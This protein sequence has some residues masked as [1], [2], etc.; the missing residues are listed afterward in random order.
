MPQSLSPDFLVAPTRTGALGRLLAEVRRRLARADRGRPQAWRVE[1]VEVE[2][3]P[4]DPL[5]W[6]AAQ[7]HASR[8]YWHGRGDASTTAGAG[9]ANEV[10]GTLAQVGPELESR[11]RGLPNSQARYFGGLRFEPDQAPDPEWAA[12]ERGR[13]VL[14]RVELGV[15][16]GRPVLA[17]NLVLPRDAQQP[18]A[19]VAALEGVAWPE[20]ETPA[21][22]PLPVGRT[23]APEQAAWR[24]GVERALHAFSAAALDKVVLARRARYDFDEPLDPFALVRSLEGAT[25]S[26]F[27]FLFQP[28]PGVAFLGASPERLLR[29]DG[30]TLLSEA[31][32][33]TRPR[34][35]SDAADARLREELKM[36]DKD[37]REHGFV[38]EQ[39]QAVLTPFCETIDVDAETSDMTLARGRHLYA[40]IAASL[41][42][43]VR[44]LD[45][46]R[47]LHPTPAV[48]GTP[49]PDA[50]ALVAAIEPFDRGW[51]AGPVGWI[52]REA[53]EFAVGIRSG[54]VQQHGGGA[55]LSLYSGAGIVR[56]STPEAEWAEIEH[57]ISDFARV[58]ALDA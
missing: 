36:S 39:I 24:Q 18:E 9:V 34:G 31:V 25:P 10:S 52:G 49:T 53:A 33:G 23:D 44:T 30:P 14:P 22:L 29:R 28:R 26:C 5:A 19:V 58:L 35:T 3:E 4:C 15:R 46:L 8:V 1:R 48:G 57:K 17:A 7:P 6:L 11:I 50:L 45:V 16:E 13:F 12:F 32:A 56:G 40:G 54:L 2:A 41:K 38:R 42:P 47:A 55:S 21:D 27:H 43:G 20:A 37:Q 51:Y